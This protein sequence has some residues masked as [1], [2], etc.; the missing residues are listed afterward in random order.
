M[1]LSGGFN[2]NRLRNRAPGKWRWRFCAALCG[3]LMCLGILLLLTGIAMALG[4][5]TQLLAGLGPLPVIAVG[6]TLC[7]LGITGW[8][9]CRRRRQ[10]G[11]LDMAP[12]LLK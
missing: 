8:R 1:K 2:A 5:S 11:G 6:V 3:L 4:E 10:P 12:G 7:L 9:R